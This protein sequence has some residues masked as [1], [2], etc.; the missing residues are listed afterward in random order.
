VVAP[1]LSEEE[2]LGLERV[3]ILHYSGKPNERPWD[4]RPNDKKN[5]GN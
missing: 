3:E 1:D 4:M 5:D 2:V